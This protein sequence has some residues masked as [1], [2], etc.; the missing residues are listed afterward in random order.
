MTVQ[1]ESPVS[2][3]GIFLIQPYQALHI[4]PH[5]LPR[6]L[7]RPV[8]A[9]TSQPLPDDTPPPILGPVANVPIRI[10]YN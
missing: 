3:P 10:F 4:L 9:K 5:H 8:Q 7:P 2:L 1:N 6:P